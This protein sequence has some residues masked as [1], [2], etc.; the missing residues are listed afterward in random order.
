MQS[1]NI[2]IG[3]SKRIP[4]LDILRFVAVNLVIFFHG[5]GIQNHPESF[6]AKL[7]NPIA[8]GG[9]LG[10]DLFFV[11]SGFLVS[12]L[13]F[14][15]LLK[16][17]H[18]SIGSF[19]IRRA[20]KI[21]P[22]FYFMMILS[23][24]GIFTL[25]SPEMIARKLQWKLFAS[26]FLFV[27]NYFQNI[28]CHTWSLAVEE[29]FYLALLGIIFFLT[30]P[31]RKQKLSMLPW[32][33]IPFCLL[34]LVSRSLFTLE[35]PNGSAPLQTHFRLDSLFFGV[36]LSYLYHFKPRSLLFITHRK[37]TAWTVS[38]CLVM[39]LFIG[40]PHA[41]WVKTIGL[42]FAYL[43]FGGILI[44]SLAL[45]H[46]KGSTKS[47]SDFTAW[48][49]Q[50]SYSIYLWHVPIQV[51]I[52]STLVRRFGLQ[53]SFWTTQALFFILSW[54]LGILMAKCIEFPLLSIR[55]RIFR[56]SY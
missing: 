42:T 7:I 38:L 11:L 35:H 39:S 54:T 26:E 13:L 14:Q 12:G 10:V 5:G 43:G 15:E 49:G 2:L 47:I 3:N 22:A 4:Q 16:T 30:G 21:Y 9:W 55:N 1:S 41:L 23:W 45:P 36:L 27:Q 53:D 50:H 34:V 44:L 19:L 51:V 31:G 56:K 28:W 29:H 32:I 17:G 52:L 6:S 48:I 40:G 24:I 25:T 18:I 8:S 46:P 37:K 33:V 20:F